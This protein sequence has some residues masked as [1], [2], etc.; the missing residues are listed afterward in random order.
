MGFGACGTFRDTRIGI[1]KTKMNALTKISPRGSIW[2]I[3]E[4]ALI[5]VKLMDTREVSVC[6]T[7]HTAFSGDTVQRSSKVGGKH[8]AAEVPVPPAVKDY[9]C[10][11]EGVDLSDQLI[12]SY[13][14][15]RKSRKWYVTVLHLFIDIAVTNSYCI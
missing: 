15:R 6:S 5:F 12:D 9:N 1:P 4:G 13:S 11:M 7:L 2:W 14:S 8:T 3:R 10:F